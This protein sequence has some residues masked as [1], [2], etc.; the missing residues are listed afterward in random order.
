MPDLKKDWW[1]ALDESLIARAP[2]AERSASRLLHLDAL[3]NPPQHRMMRDFPSLLQRGD[4]LILNNT[5]VI[6]ARLHVV[7]ETGGAV[8][9]LVI[10]TDG[11][12]R[13]RC[14]SRSSKGLKPGQRLSV[15]GGPVFTV[16]GPADADLHWI[17]FPDQVLKVLDVW[18]EIPLPPYMERSANDDDKLRYQTIFARHPGSVAAPTAGL[19]F[20]VSLTDAL[21]DA[22]VELT[23]VTLHV[24]PGTFLPMRV[25]DV[26]QHVMHAERC[27]VSASTVD[28]VGRAKAR[29]NRVFSVG[30]TSTRA[31][32]SAARNGGLKPYTGDTRL[33][34]R[35]G[36][37]FQVIDG[38]LTNFHLPESTLLM[39]V[40]AVAGKERICAA[41]EEA[42]RL[43]YRFFS[44]GDA[45]FL[46]RQPTPI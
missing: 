26:D 21:K 3:G 16:E 30:T 36:F 7:K 45:S 5:R 8:E 35:P 6:P 12:Q 13:A 41:Y 44:Y 34:V 37:Q 18:G 43:R 23:E 25:D 39:L 10:D 42:Q 19:H 11:N 40:A 1:Y 17:V 9:L 27:E 28:A 33:F 4:L 29:G 32:E 38:L 46:E 31:I 22:G 14:M 2:P 24:G 20:D 15:P